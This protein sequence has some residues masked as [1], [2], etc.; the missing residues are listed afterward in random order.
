MEMFKKADEK[1]S[2]DPRTLNYTIWKAMARSK[3]ISSFAS[4]LI[5]LPFMYGFVNRHWI[6]MADVMLEK[7]PGVRK[8]H[9]LRIIGKLPA[10]FNTALK[11]L[12]KKTMWN[13]EDCN[14]SPEQWGSRPHRA[15][16]DAAMTKLLTFESARLF[17]DT[18]TSVQYDAVAHFDRIHPANSAVYAQKTRVE[19]TV[20]KCIQMTMERLESHP[21]TVLGISDMY[22]SQLPGEPFIGGEVQGKADVPQKSSQQADVIIKVHKKLAS[23]LHFDSPNMQRSIDHHNTKYVDDNDG[24]VSASP[25]SEDPVGEVLEANQHSAQ[26]WRDL[27][28]L[29]GGLVAM[30]KSN[31]QLIAW[32]FVKGKLE[33]VHSTDSQL[34]LRDEQGAYSVIKFL[35]PDQ[36]NQGLGFRL[37]PNGDQ[38]PHHTATLDAITKICAN[39]KSAHLTQNE[40]RMVMYERIVPKLSYAFGLTSLSKKQCHSYNTRIRKAFAGPVGLNSNYPGAILYGSAEYGGMEFPE[41][42][43]LQ[44]QVQIPYFIKQLRWDKEVANDMLVT[45]DRAQLISGFVRPILEQTSPVVDF[46]DNSYIFDL[47]RRMR[48][49]D[50]TLWIEKAWCPHLQ[51]ENDQSL[52]ERFALLP[53][54]T[55]HKMFKLN[56]VR[57]Y[58]RVITLAD[59]TDEAGTHIPDGMLTGEWQA[60]SDLRWPFQPRPSDSAWALFRKC[61]RD[62]FSPKTPPTQR[63]HFSIQLGTPLGRWFN[64]PRATWF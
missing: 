11:L 30:H 32:E 37:C 63:A 51:R 39:A 60:G 7:K 10:E 40:A 43:A 5:S 23:G 2:S 49:I 1:T 8:I 48:E 24:H 19:S 45:I 27:V 14:P 47:R 18:M 17:K 62:A 33:M 42:V 16:I 58:L 61:I 59:L 13:F 12:F 53:H 35:S 20:L 57:L 41:A 55:R 28:S 46:V 56:S 44:D 50:A 38:E 9:L 22:Y 4:V 36:P 29:T 26:V 15:A 6:K 25:D 3:Y 52:M 54:M 64:V 31:W 21:Q 34:V